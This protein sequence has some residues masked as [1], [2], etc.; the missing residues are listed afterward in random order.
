VEKGN[1]AEGNSDEG[2][3]VTLSIEQVKSVATYTILSKGKAITFKMG[4]GVWKST[5]SIT[6]KNDVVAITSMIEAIVG[7]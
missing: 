2:I 1:L 4:G 5:R 7:K 3:P 6:K